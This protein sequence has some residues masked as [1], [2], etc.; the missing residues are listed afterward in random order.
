MT[1][2]GEEAENAE[3]VQDVLTLVNKLAPKEHGID[4]EVSDDGGFLIHFQLIDYTVHTYD[5]HALMGVVN[6]FMAGFTAG[7]KRVNDEFEGE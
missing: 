1:N 5:E 4:I 2:W 6:A 7:M 3:T